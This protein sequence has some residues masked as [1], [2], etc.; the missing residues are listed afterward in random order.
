MQKNLTSKSIY[1]LI[2]FLLLF[3]A[4][5]GNIISAALNVENYF[6]NDNLVWIED[7][8]DSLGRYS[9]PYF[10]SSCEFS[11]FQ[12]TKAINYIERK[13]NSNLELSFY[14]TPSSILCHDRPVSSSFTNKFFVSSSDEKIAIGIGVNSD[15]ENIERMAK[16]LLLFLIVSA[17]WSKFSLHYKKTKVSNSAI[18]FFIILIIFYS[19]LVFNSISNAISNFV[20]FI[21]LGNF[22]FLLISN[23]YSKKIILKSIVSILFLPLMFLDLNISFIWLTVLYTLNLA[24]ISKNKVNTYLVV[25]VLL[26][27]SSFVFNLKRFNFQKPEAYFDWILFTS[28]RHHGSIVDLNNGLQSLVLLV[29]L[30]LILFVVYF[31]FR[32][33]DEK[34]ISYHEFFDSLIV[35]FFIWIF[36]YYLSTLHHLINF[37][38][39]K[40][41]G[42]SESIDSILNIQAD[43]INWRGLTSSHELT[44]FWL[45]LISSISLYRFITTKKYY[46]GIS[47]VLSIL[48][49]NWNSQRS[50]LLLFLIIVFYLFL[51]SFRLKGLI[52]LVPFLI[53]FY[54]LSPDSVERL[55]Y[56]IQ[57]HSISS[58]IEQEYKRELRNSLQRYERLGSVTTLPDYKFED[59]D[60]W[61]EFYE[62]ETG[63]S[64]KTILGGII[65]VEQLVN[66][67]VQWGR[68]LYFE[69]IEG[70]NLFGKGPGQS[71]QTLVELIEKPHSLYLTTFYQYGWIGILIILGLAFYS[72][73]NLFKYRFNFYDLILITFFINGIKAELLLTHNQLILFI[74]FVILRIFT[75]N[76]EIAKYHDV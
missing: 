40:F 55:S 34:N 61:Y 33:S 47:L 11:Q 53:L 19:V 7:S 39:Y 10:D 76:E 14:E 70:N 2:I 22:L 63:I 72:F 41:F 42:L 45:F 65:L 67:G 16:F 44:G 71:H 50:A 5:S 3:F 36:G 74:M 58:E 32:K 29:D 21:F 1:S 17:F 25:F 26:L 6:A 66:R 49:M 30:I 68:Y 54:L 9:M 69:D 51:K 4:F 64:N 18:I 28:H 56:R 23:F 27:S 48:S 57:T 52:I 62:L 13:N 38:I 75:F 12:L 43:G 24:F 60:N 73:I 8:K 31:L 37:E 46:Y 20:I 59:L 35:G 15:L